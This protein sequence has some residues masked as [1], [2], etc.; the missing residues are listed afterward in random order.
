MTDSGYLF[1]VR[2]DQ[3]DSVARRE[4]LV[5]DSVDVGSRSHIYT[6]SRL[7]EDEAPAAGREPTSQN[8]LLLVPTAQ[9][10]HW[11]VRIS[12]SDVEALQDQIGPCS[13]QALI[14]EWQP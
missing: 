9:S 7:L 12:R 11:S 2:R 5:K 1:E 13:L 10:G 4:G 14:H 8:N 3:Q 6:G